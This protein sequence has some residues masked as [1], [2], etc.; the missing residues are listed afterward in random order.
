[1]R[2]RRIE[3]NSQ[4]FRPVVLQNS[5]QN[6][7]EQ[8]RHFGRHTARRIHSQHRRIKR[9][10]DMRHRVYKKQSL[11]RFSHPREYTKRRLCLMLRRNSISSFRPKR[12]ISLALLERRQH[13]LKCRRCDSSPSKNTKKRKF[14]AAE[15]AAGNLDYVA[16][17]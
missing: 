2:S 1:G 10:I 4:I 8:E 3:Y 16:N 14:P 5:L 12:G 9:S 11:R 15:S 6:V 7:V 17:K 13:F